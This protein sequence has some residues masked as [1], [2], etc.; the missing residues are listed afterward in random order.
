VRGR[1]RVERT[2]RPVTTLMTAGASDGEGFFRAEV[3]VSVT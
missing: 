1:G 2:V 3:D